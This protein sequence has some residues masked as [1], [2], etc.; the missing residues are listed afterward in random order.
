MAEISWWLVVVF[1]SS[2]IGMA[3]LSCLIGMRPKIENPLWWGLYVVWVG[4]ALAAGIK[5]PFSTLLVSSILA[6]LLHGTTSALLLDQ[7]ITNNPW[8]ANRMQGP[9]GKLASQFMVMGIVFGIAFGAVVAGIA[10]G[11]SRI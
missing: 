7:Y 3:L 2:G 6:G 4:I 5:A 1:A 8:H 10:W 9:R 11:I